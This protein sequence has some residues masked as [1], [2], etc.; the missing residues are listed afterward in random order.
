MLLAIARMPGAM[1]NMGAGSVIPLAW[2]GIE[3]EPA[4]GFHQPSEINGSEFARNNI[5]RLV[6]K[7]GH[8]ITVVDTPGVETISVDTPTSNRL[9]LTESHADTGGRP[10]IVLETAGDMILAV[11]NGRI[12]QQAMFRS[13]DVGD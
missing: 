11:P 2:T 12:H 3:E 13:A 9:M 8:R 4:A 6:T 1:C 5:K 7:S 10:A